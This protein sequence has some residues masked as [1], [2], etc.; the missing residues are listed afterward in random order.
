MLQTNMAGAVAVFQTLMRS[1]QADADML[2]LL[3]HALLLQEKPVS[4]EGAYRQALILRADDMDAM[5]GLTKCLID[6]QEPRRPY[7]E[8][9][10]LL[11]SAQAFGERPDVARYLEQIR[12]L[13][14]QR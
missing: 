1:G 14:A 4:A 9:A 12:R 10:T 3:G 2:T 11:E 8:A 6:Q 5:R 7:R 13:I